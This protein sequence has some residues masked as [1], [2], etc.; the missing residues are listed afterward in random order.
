MERRDKWHMRQD[1]IFPAC[2]VFC[3]RILRNVSI[4]VGTSTLGKHLWMVWYYTVGAPM[5]RTYWLGR[6]CW[7]ISALAVMNAAASNIFLRLDTLVGDGEPGF[8]ECGWRRWLLEA[9]F[10]QPGWPKFGVC[11]CI[12]LQ[13]WKQIYLDWSG[14]VEFLSMTFMAIGWNI[15]GCTATSVAF[16]LVWTCCYGC[17]ACRCHA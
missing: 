1:L 12:I 7:I 11:I 9:A 6:F 8:A 3:G 10:Q 16:Q 14:Y 13:I 5:G 15:C 17:H 4:L 2:G